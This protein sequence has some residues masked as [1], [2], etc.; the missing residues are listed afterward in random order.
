MLMA[1]KNL[2]L[3][4]FLAYSLEISVISSFHQSLSFFSFPSSAFFQVNLTIFFFSCCAS[5]LYSC[6]SIWQQIN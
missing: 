3:F 4:A 2:L 1:V 6:V 5:S